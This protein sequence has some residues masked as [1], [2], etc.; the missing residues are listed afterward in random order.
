MG[1]G[2]FSERVASITQLHDLRS[3]A[4]RWL[5]EAGVDDEMIDAV[6]LVTSEL[7]TNAF[8]HGSTDAVTVEITSSDGALIV[9]T[10]HVDHHLAT[11]GLET[12]MPSPA[13]E[14]GRGLA[15]VDRLVDTMTLEIDPPCVDRR[16]RLRI[17]AASGR[18]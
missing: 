5:A 10:R 1:L 12:S 15:I 13:A 9:R 3:A 8:V 7:C 16:C 11:L 14:R 18:W 2:T 6:N 17:S 4:S